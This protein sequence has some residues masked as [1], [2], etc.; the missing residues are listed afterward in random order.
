MAPHAAIRSDR[1]PA[2]RSQYRGAGDADHCQ[3][4]ASACGLPR[5]SEPGGFHQP[6]P[7]AID[8][9]HPD[10][11]CGTGA[12]KPNAER[13]G[14]LVVRQTRGVAPAGILESGCARAVSAEPH[15]HANGASGTMAQ[16]RV[17]SNGLRHSQR[18]PR[19]TTGWDGSGLH[20]Q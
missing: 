19:Q 3:R 11:G 6:E 10:P 20:Q 12:A 2:D 14:T 4:S 7:G 15:Q 9:G 1:A 18:R 13:L 16:Q 17:R 8:G 5:A